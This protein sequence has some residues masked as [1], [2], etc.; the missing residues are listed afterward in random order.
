MKKI[1]LSIC[2]T[3]FVA[4]FS[5]QS[6]YGCSYQRVE[7][8][9]KTK[10]NYKQWLKNFNG[11][12]FI[13]RVVK[14]EKLENSYELKVTFEVERFWKGAETG[15]S[16]IYT[17]KD[18]VLCG[19]NYVEDQSYF[20]IADSYGGRL[21]TDLCSEIGYSELKQ[22]FIKKLGKGRKPKARENA[23]SS[24]RSRTNHWT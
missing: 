16:V 4:G 22:A 2:L 13:G 18:G 12:A 15:E 11:V 9:T 23:S 8:E 19:V 10:I 5:G 17:P 14:I 3:I 1:I 24:T 20:I 6:I 7:G 21:S